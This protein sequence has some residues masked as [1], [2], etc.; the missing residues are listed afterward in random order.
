[1]APDCLSG[2]NT[3]SQS[4]SVPDSSDNLPHAWSNRAFSL[5]NK[6]NRRPEAL[7]AVFV[8]LVSCMQPLD[9][10]P[11]AAKARTRPSGEFLSGYQ[12]VTA[13]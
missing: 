10:M 5:P 4:I 7:I 13:G 3:G 2:Q 1:M 12:D 11:D 6:Q 8:Q 9:F